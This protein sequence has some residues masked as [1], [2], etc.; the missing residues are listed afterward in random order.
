MKTKILLILL[1]VSSCGVG[2]K[3]PDWFLMGKKNDDEF[4]YGYGSGLTK[5]TAEYDAL[6]NLKER[7]YT[8]VS[9]EEFMQDVAVNNKMQNEFFKKINAK[10]VDVAIQSYE[11]SKIDNQKEVIFIEI[12]AD[13]KK[14]ADWVLDSLKNRSSKILPKVTEYQNAE[15]V[16]QKLE[17]V[18]NL[19]EMCGI[20]VRLEKFYNG[21]GFAMPQRICTP[22]LQVY[23]NFKNENT[24]QISHTNAVIEEILFNVF[25]KRFT[26]S[27]NSKNMISYKTSVKTEKLSSANVASVKIDIFQNNAKSNF[28]SKNCVGSSSKGSKE[29]IENAY[30][31]CLLQA[32]GLLFSEFFNIK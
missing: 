4:V 27:Q 31:N 2:V 28:Y 22:I 24:V 10:S 5:G 29:A 19:K 16:I 9:S 13:K 30:N 18:K 8:V 21:L 11:I 26:I 23:Y 25:S 1:L 17:V 6:A 20:Y 32:K 12:K 14:L 3:T 15:N 7:I